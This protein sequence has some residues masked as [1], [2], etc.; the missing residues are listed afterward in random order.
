MCVKVKSPNIFITLKNELV[1]IVLNIEEIR[2]KDNE[3]RIARRKE[4]VI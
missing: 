1:W 4:G 3:N 2:D